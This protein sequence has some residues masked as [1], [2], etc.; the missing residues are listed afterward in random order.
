MTDNS[1]STLIK[2]SPV[3]ASEDSIRRAAG[4]IRGTSG[5]RILVLSDGRVAGTVSERGISA[6]IASSDDVDNALNSN[7]GQIVETNGT[8]INIGTPMKDA[9]QVFAATGE[10]VLPVIDNSGS[11]QGVIY[12]RDLV[13][14]L[15]KDL[16][17]PSIAGMATPLGVYLTTGSISGGAG[18][19]GLFLTGASLGLMM[20]VAGLIVTGLQTLFS[21]LTGFP[22]G[23]FLGSPPLTM[24]PN[25]YDLPFYIST[26]LTVVIFLLIMR[27]SP[28]SGYHAAEHM[29]VHA[30]EAGESLE[31]S[32]VVQM[33]RVHPRC[34]TNLLAA[35]G[36]FII[37]TSK[38]DSEIAV[39]LALLIVVL[40]W[41][42]IGGML[43]YYATTKKPNARQLASGIAAGS[44]LLEKYQKNPNFQLIGF[45]KVWKLGFPQTFAGMATMLGILSLFSRYISV[46]GLF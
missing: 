3:V 32:T 19:L 18:N 43:Q 17:P 39:L 14:R 2:R 35:A 45:Q 44:E 6:Y 36:V 7:I 25:L 31:P 5:S 23:A 22:V 24:N 33:P 38:I 42:S 4:L 30:I 11:Y 21:K 12:R 34:G 9:A 8:F 27:L 15:T 40:G 20:T 29:T 28:L 1:I 10:D 13:A 37:V 26:A 16:R 46:P 41:R